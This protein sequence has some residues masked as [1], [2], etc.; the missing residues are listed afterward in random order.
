MAENL[1]NIPEEDAQL[2][3][4]LRGIELIK[5]NPQLFH[6][7]FWNLK[8]MYEIL[9]G[10]K[11][12]FL[13]LTGAAISVQY[14]LGQRAMRPYN[15]Y[16]NVHQGMARFAFGAILGLSVGYL[17][18][19]DRQRLGNAYTAERLRR[20]YPESMGLTTTDL[21]KLKGVTAGH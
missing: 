8:N 4:K 18:W 21:W 17:K 2:S 7:E 16:V 6:V 11:T 12:Q 13:G 19:G 10:A 1:N 14:Y 20:R 15:F 9:G 5:H 3:L